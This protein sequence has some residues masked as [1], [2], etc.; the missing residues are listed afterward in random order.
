LIA[1]NDGQSDVPPLPEDVTA[2]GDGNIDRTD[3]PLYPHISE[4]FGASSS[5]YVLLRPDNYIGLISKDF[6][7]EVVAS[8]FNIVGF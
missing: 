7:P 1:F 8:Y 5:F 3:I 6:S 2:M 4:M